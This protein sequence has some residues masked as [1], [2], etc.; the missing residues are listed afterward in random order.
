MEIALY[1]DA[2]GFFTKGGPRRDF[3]TGPSLGSLF[4]ACVARAL[5][6]YWRELGAPDPFLVVE[7]GAGD[8]RLARDVLRAEPACT[9]ALRYVLVERSAARRAEQRT[10]L[11][12]EPADEALGPFVP[13]ADDEP[14]VPAPGAG[15]VVTA[16]AELPAVDAADTVVFAN[17][18]LDNLPFG[19][20][21]SD[22]R[23]WQEVRVGFDGNGFTEV[24]VP[25]PEL[26][27]PVAPAGARV[28]I[29]RGLRAWFEECERVVRRGRVVLVDY[30]T[31]A[32]ELR[33]RTHRAHARGAAPLDAPG[34]QDITADVVVDH[35]RAAAAPFVP[36]LDTIQA[37]WLRD[38]GIDELAADGARRWREGA[39]RGDLDALA[40]RSHVHEAGA[41]TDPAGLGAYR[42]VVLER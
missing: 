25:L 3:V 8:G 9:R 35:L 36:V 30:M 1:D 29:P 17:E 18:L 26:A 5:D 4:G 13:R 39:K 23:G 32:H 6:T 14:P 16:V 38:L 10:R 19:I 21:E 12:I 27:E 7:A 2:D 31:D 22:G 42:V 33:L 28:P 37:E 34:E 20:A 15:P 24:L 40:G 41:L 11:P